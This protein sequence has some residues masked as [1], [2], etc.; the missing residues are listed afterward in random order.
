[1]EVRHAEQLRAEIDRG[2]AGDKVAASDPAAA[3]LGT[4]VS[5]AALQQA[6]AQETKRSSSAPHRPRR[7]CCSRL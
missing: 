1:M 5:T 6:Y 4:D 3:P 7:E 2:A